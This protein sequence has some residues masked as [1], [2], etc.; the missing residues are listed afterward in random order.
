MPVSLADAASSYAGN[1]AFVDL[2]RRLVW[3]GETEPSLVSAYRMLDERLF[4]VREA[5]NRRFAELLAD[6]LDGGSTR[7]EDR[8]AS[9]RSSLR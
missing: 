5:A 7:S 1:E 9:R 3:R 8:S 4:E 6:W 2:A